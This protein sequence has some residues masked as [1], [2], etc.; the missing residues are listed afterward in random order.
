METFINFGCDERT[1]RS[2]GKL[3]KAAALYRAIG[4]RD[5]A[6]R[7]DFF[8]RRSDGFQISCQTADQD[9]E[10]RRP[11]GCGGAFATCS[12][13]ESGSRGVNV[14]SALSAAHHSATRASRAGLRDTSGAET[15]AMT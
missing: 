13:N 6:L 15:A 14:G 2:L 11:E 12:G 9:E 1:A 4:R 3:K 5:E 10:P 8:S 7:G